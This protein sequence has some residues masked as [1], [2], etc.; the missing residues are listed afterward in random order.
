MFTIRKNLSEFDGVPTSQRWNNDTEVFQ[1]SYD[2]GATWVDTPESDPRHN[3]TFIT[4]ETGDQC[5]VAQGMSNFVRQF[6]DSTF[7]AFNIVGIS[8]AAINVGLLFV[9]PLALFWRIAEVVADGIV[10]I[11][12]VT[13]A[14]TFTE[15]VYDQIRDIF[16][17]YLD[18]DGHMTQADFDAAGAALQ[19]EIGGSAFNITLAAMYNLYGLVGFSNAGIELAEAADCS[20]AECAWCVTNNV[21]EPGDMVLQYGQVIS[22]N[23]HPDG[24][25]GFPYLSLRQNITI[26]AGTHITQFGFGWS[27]NGRFEPM[28]VTCTIWNGTVG[29]GSIRQTISTQQGGADPLYLNDDLTDGVFGFQADISD[30]GGANQYDPYITHVYW[31]GT[32]AF[33]P[34][35]VPC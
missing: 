1:S 20:G 12:S 4:P 9:P 25:A 5:D 24:S 35:G 27:N 2:G 30:N 8:S 15:S 18:A 21:A 16:Y 33:Q 28:T 26:P 19:T 31:I 6:V 22:G 32:G 17:C 34:D 23:W 3:P 14:A 13:L 11:G 7:D 29:G 10:A